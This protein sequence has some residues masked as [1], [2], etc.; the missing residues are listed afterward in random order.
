[1]RFPPYYCVLLI[2]LLER[3][4]AFPSPRSTGSP[5]ATSGTSP[6]LALASQ[7]NRQA[8]IVHPAWGRHRHSVCRSQTSGT[9]V[10]ASNPFQSLF[11]NVAS[12]ISNIQQQGMTNIRPDKISELKALTAQVLS[13]HNIGSWDEVRSALSSKQTS[14]ER[15]F[16]SNLGKGYGKPSPLHKLRLFDESNDEE[17]VR[18][19]L[20]RDSASWC[21]YCQKVWMTLEQK[22]IPYRIEKVNMRCYGDKPASFLAM[23]PNGNIPVAIIDGVT[24]NQSNDI[25]Y[26]LEER[27]PDHEPLVPNDP[28]QRMKSQELLRLERQIFSA[29]MY[30]LTSGDSRDGRL[31]ESFVSV[32]NDVEAELSATKGGFFLG[33]KASIVDMMFAPFLERM[34]ASMLF[35]KGFQIRVAPGEKTNFPAVNRWFDA[36]ETLESY[37]LTKSDYYTHCWDLP[38]QLGGCVPEDGS[39]PFQNAING[40]QPGSWH[41]PLAPN[42][43]G[44]EPDWM[45]AGDEGAAKRE[46]VERI[47]GNSQA[48]A[49]FAS[50]GAGSTGFPRYGAPLADPNAVS[51]ESIQ[52]FVDASLKI[53]SQKLLE[54]NVSNCDEAMKDLASVLKKGG[55]G[56]LVEQVALSL[57]YLRDRV[58][59]PR[60]MRLPAARQLRAH[61]NW[62]IDFCEQ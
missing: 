39:Q 1:M 55:G 40:I 32:L 42:N 62:A 9:A 49:K 56:E 2:R 53:I 17:D 43:G 29:W 35:F 3:S 27:F 16:R 6:S 10:C 14:E 44:L 18:V 38:P 25:M 47:S 30:W 45:W 33:K 59:V 11:G 36:M 60:D 34:C 13:S 12:S 48:I 28:K 58:G 61:L 50:R 54:N 15:N 23:Q 51:N 31:Q 46:A 19:T 5:R 21:P 4:S 8:S 52:P 22:R 24:Y 41:L 37:Q 7:E 20:F 26:A 57:A